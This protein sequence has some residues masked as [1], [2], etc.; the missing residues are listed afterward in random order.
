MIACTAQDTVAIVVYGTAARVQLYSTPASDKQTILNAIYA[1]YTEGAT[2][3]EAGLELGYQLAMQAYRPDASNRVILCSDGVAN[4]GNTSPDAILGKI[5]GY[6]EEGITLTTIGFGMGNFNDVLMEQLAD[7]GNGHYAYIDD[8]DEAHKL[9]VEDLTSTLE[10]IAR[11]P[12]CRW[13]SIPM[14]SP[15][16]GCWA[17]RTGPLLTKISATTVWMPARLGAGHSATAMYAVQFRPGATGR[18]ATVQLRWQDPETY[19]VARDQRQ[20]EHLGPG[21]RFQQRLAP[22]PAG[23]PGG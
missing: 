14:W 8:L 13:I 2:N 18:I 9:F 7:D 1:L 11:M 12:K 6:V 19:E 20:P 5:R 21:S 23:Y 15:T 10:V 16:T 22:L 17:T 3:A 4:V